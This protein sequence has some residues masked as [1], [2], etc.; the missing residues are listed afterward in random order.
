MTFLF[1]LT[2]IISSN[3]CCGPTIHR[4]LTEKMMTVSVLNEGLVPVLFCARKKRSYPNPPPL[5]A[6]LGERLL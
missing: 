6:G 2:R 3:A 1:L 4:I 5:G